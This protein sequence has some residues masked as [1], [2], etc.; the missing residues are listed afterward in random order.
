[1]RVLVACEE[2]QAV[3]REF[4]VL[5]ILEEG[6]KTIYYQKMFYLY[7]IGTELIFLRIHQ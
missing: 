4:R 2:S 5:S 1:M 3:T 7:G 6:L